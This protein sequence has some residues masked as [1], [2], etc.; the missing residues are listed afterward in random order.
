M[1]YTDAEK[2]KK[3]G[4]YETRC[5]SQLKQYFLRLLYIQLVNG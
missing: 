1:Q 2:K 3:K 5:T 4:Y